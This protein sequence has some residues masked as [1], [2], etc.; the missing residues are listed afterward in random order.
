MALSN[1]TLAL[2]AQPFENGGGPS[3]SVIELIWTT[4]GAERYLPAQGNKLDTVLG[5][6]RALRDR[7]S[8]P[9]DGDAAAKKLDLVVA[10][11]ATRLMMR[12]DFDSDKLDAALAKDGFSASTGGSDPRD[13]PVDRLAVFLGKLFGSG[14]TY[15]VAR[16]HY[17]QGGRAFER[18]DWEAANAQFRSA[19]DATFDTLAHAHGCPPKKKGGEAR[20]WLE[21]QGLLAKDEGD[22]VRAF[23]AFA[24]RA[25]SHAGVS[26]ETDAQLRR[27]F[28]TALISFAIAKLG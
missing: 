22:L 18:D 13:E 14:A 12:S 20:Q 9:L 24:G 17:E 19:C 1:Q 15:K 7:A 27:H 5:G 23:I 28:A 11:L 26:D 6:L 4:A 2:L 16:N 21:A 3:R 8:D 10:D 25:G